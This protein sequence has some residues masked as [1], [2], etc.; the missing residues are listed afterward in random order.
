MYNWSI[1]SGGRGGTEH[2]GHKRGP[3]QGKETEGASRGSRV[4]INGLYIVGGGGV[5]NIA[6]TRE[7]LDR[8]K[9]LKEWAKAAEYVYFK[10]GL[11]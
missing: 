5:Q 1:Y 3:G 11:S 6:A 10:S 2:C 8:A 7:D 9:K 4:C